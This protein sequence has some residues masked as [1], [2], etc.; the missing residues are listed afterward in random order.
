M[1][2]QMHAQGIVRPSKSPWA[3]PIVL[4]PKKDGSLHFCVDFRKLNSITKKDVYP[5]PCVELDEDAC[6]KSAFTTHHGFFEFTRMPF[7]LCNAPA[8]F[9]RVIQAVLAG[10]EWNSCF[11]YLDDILIASRTLEE[12]LRHIKEVFGRLACVLSLKSAF[13]S[14]MRSPIWVT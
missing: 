6:T 1:L 13:F 4:V 11:I 12:H 2:S 7:G 8:T 10:L 3:S 9:Q 14:A 5:L